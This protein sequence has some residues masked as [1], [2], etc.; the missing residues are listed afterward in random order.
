MKPLARLHLA[1]AVYCG[2]LVSLNWFQV[3]HYARTQGL[4]SEAIS[5]VGLALLLS[6]IVLLVLA[7]RILRL[8]RWHLEQGRR[9]GAGRW[10]E[11]WSVALYALPLLWH[12][13]T[14]SSWTEADGAVA[15][16]TG[17]FGHAWSLWVFVFALGGLLLAQIGSRLSSR[18]HDVR[19]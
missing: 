7:W 11:S 6:I 9:V 4:T 10:I 5:P 3:T 18:Q 2:V 1:S 16:T 12:R 8:V 19:P 15:T 17:G 14:T 13:V